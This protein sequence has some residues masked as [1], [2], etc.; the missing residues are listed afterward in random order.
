MWTGQ[1]GLRNGLVDHQGGLWKAL[2]VADQLYQE[3]E[4]RRKQ[5]KQLK[6]QKQVSPVSSTNP[7][8]SNSTIPLSNTSNT[9]TATAAT[10]LPKRF[11]VQTFREQGRS[12]FS[13]LPF[14]RAMVRCLGGASLAGGAGRGVAAAS[15][16]AEPLAMCDEVV[17]S[18]GFSSP[19]SWGLG[20]GSKGGLLAASPVLPLLWH[21]LRNFL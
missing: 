2:E 12:V 18:T 9:T 21:L 15:S 19:E 1:Q 7:L 16:V 5:Q 8:I 4:A 10:K 17:L 14:A 3:Q 11:R 13:G 20:G 6:K